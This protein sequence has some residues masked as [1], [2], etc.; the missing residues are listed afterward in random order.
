MDDIKKLIRQTARQLK[1]G[2][3]EPDFFELVR[4]IENV[5]RDMP[6]IGYAHNPAREPLHFGQTPYLRFPETALAELDF[7]ENTGDMAL[8]YVYFFGLLGVNGPMPLE[9]TNYV[10]QRSQNYYD[11]TLRRF[12][13]IVNHKM[14]SLF[15]RAWAS[16]EQAVSF[17]RKNDDLIGDIVLSLSGGFAGYLPE[18]LPEYTSH[19]FSRFLS[20]YPR[21]GAGLEKM[22]CSF[23]H[24]KT[25]VAPNRPSA[26]VIPTKFRCALGME[27]TA[28][29]GYS[30]Q[31]GGRYYSRGKKFVI[32]IGPT[33]LD[34][35]KTMLPGS[36]KFTQLTQL[37]NLYM[38]RPL[39]Y[40]VTFL[41]TEDSVL[42]CKL[43]GSAALGRGLWLMSNNCSDPEQ[44]LTI[45]ASRLNAKYH[46]S[47]Y[48]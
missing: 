16:C 26:H 18:G 39:E 15:Y 44:K 21:S 11:R 10:F 13:D 38:D 3:K 43:N 25:K 6:R 23:F 4:R 20:I 42:R 34:F 46:K 33:S 17:D 45:G 47:S 19:N 31:I 36:H 29:L 27:D 37:V 5:Y 1:N 48:A 41:L 28:V 35:C 30:A 40:D 9:F 2:G 8:I 12:L 24:V 32:E 14:L 7:S 22:I